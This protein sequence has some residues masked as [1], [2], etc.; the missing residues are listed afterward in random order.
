[1]NIFI[2]EGISSKIDWKKSAQSLDNWRV[3]K[4]ILENVQM[5]STTLNQQGLSTTYKSFNPRHPCCLWVSSSS[6]NF[7]TLV[8]H[9]KYLLEERKTRFKNPHH[10]CEIALKTIESL[11]QPNLFKSHIFSSP[12]L[13]VPVEFKTSDLIVSYRNF[14]LSK[15][16]MIYPKNKIPK[17]FQES[18]KIP[19]KII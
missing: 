7:Q 11:F 8:E 14:Y 2:L 6:V 10:K 3:N 18:R 12:P 4:M 16:N 19:Y 17:W 15:K 5:L 13:C 1:M 9:T